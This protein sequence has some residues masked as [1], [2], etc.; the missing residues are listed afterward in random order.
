MTVIQCPEIIAD[1]HPWESAPEA[2]TH[3]SA[4]HSSF[5]GQTPYARHS[6]EEGK[7]VMCFQHPITAAHS[8]IVLLARPD[9]SGTLLL[10]SLIPSGRLSWS[11]LPVRCSLKK[12]WMG[13]NRVAMSLVGRRYF[14]EA[15]KM[16]YDQGYCRRQSGPLKLNCIRGNDAW[17]QWCIHC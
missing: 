16:Q 15:Q 7:T 11:A 3:N 6:G 4:Q 5:S 2:P 10:I 1:E 17:G 12:L 13:D 14:L 9:H 8:F